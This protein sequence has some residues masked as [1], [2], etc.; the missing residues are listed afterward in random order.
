MASFETRGSSTRAIVRVPGGGKKTATFDTLKE[1]RAWA[2]LMEAKL[3]AKGASIGGTNGELFET[4]LDA[5]ASKTD[6]AKFNALRLLK[7]C[8]D[9]LAALRTE[10]T[11]THD[12]NQWIE[13]S[14]AEPSE[15]TGKALSGATVNR[16]LNLMGG[17]FGYAI[18]ALQWITVNP[19]HGA[20]RPE[21]GKARKRPLLTSKEIRA[22]RIST[23]Y[24]TDPK[25]FTL[26][27][28]VG[29]CF[30]LSLETGLRSG[31]LLRVRP[32]DYHRKERFLHVSA[33]EKGGRKGGHSGRAST[34]PSRNVPLT[35]R[36]VELL[37]QLLASMP[38]EQE[39]DVDAGFSKPPYI[40]GL[41]DS[42]RDALWRKARDQAGVEDLHFHDTKHEAATR[43]SK[44][45]DVLALSHAIGTKDVRLLRDTYYN[46]DA[47]RI[48]KMLPDQ[49][50]AELPDPAQR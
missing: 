45:I 11:T 41:H 43:L 5:V 20:A 18:K 37:D 26:T 36:A 29:A 24:D 35:G 39:P 50:S 25:L 2:Q 46:N 23:G 38:K 31:E 15:R 42:Q 47:S 14:L 7:W 19:V 4:Y 30:L 49:L 40:V 8:K 9:P 16:E 10:D 34:D 1:A 17:A 22:I 48:A 12:I 27:A 6:S 32:A 13:R 28:R 33:T 44:F 21:R 3:E